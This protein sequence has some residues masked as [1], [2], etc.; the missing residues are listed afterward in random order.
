LGPAEPAASTASEDE[1]AAAAQ[2]RFLQH[3]QDS[4]REIYL[5]L[6]SIIQAVALAFL[7]QE[8]TDGY[9]HYRLLEWIRAANGFLLIVVIW[10]EYMVAVTA[11]VW[12]PTILDTFIP[13]TLGLAE[14][15]VLRAIG[16]SQQGYSLSVAILFAIS[17]ISGLNY[18]YQT[19]RGFEWNRHVYPILHGHVDHIVPLCAG[20]LIIN[21]GLW[22]VS[23]RVRMTYGQEL[24]FSSL[25]LIPTATFLFRIV[26]DFTRPIRTAREYHLNTGSAH[27]YIRER[28]PHHRNMQPT[29]GEQEPPAG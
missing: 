10:Q 9:A 12:V 3:I 13:F 14:I 17:L 6:V 25:M 11:F 28:R 7:T 1:R 16:L 20:A 5:I 21:L 18:R 29:A 27:P 23:N 22:F 8:V 26:W 2:R 4:F 15:P 24:I 19:R